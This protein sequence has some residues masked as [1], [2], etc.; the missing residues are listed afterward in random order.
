MIRGLGALDETPWPVPVPAG[1]AQ[2]TLP[3]SV[4]GETEDLMS[5]KL[6][7][8]TKFDVEF[9]N[10]RFTVP[11]KKSDRPPTVI[12]KSVSGACRGCRLTAIMGASGAGKELAASS[13]PLL[14][15]TQVRGAV[16]RV[17]WPSLYLH[18][19]CV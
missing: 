17:Q 4:L 15:F 9:R 3:R 2:I 5:P 13:I 16:R 8:Q 1:A 6:P 12:L 11:S 14:F 7:L 19:S 10:L 18:V